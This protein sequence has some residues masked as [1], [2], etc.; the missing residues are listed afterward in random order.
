M[1]LI[2][3]I[4]NLKYLF[5]EIIQLNK[6]I[7]ELTRLFTTQSV[8]KLS[9]TFIRTVHNIPFWKRM[10]IF[11]LVIIMFQSSSLLT[12][13]F[14][15]FFL[16]SYTTRKYLPIVENVEDIIENKKL[17]VIANQNHLKQVIES[18]NTWLVK[19]EHLWKRIQKSNIFKTESENEFQNIYLSNQSL[20]SMIEGETVLIGHT[21]VK[22]LFL[23]FNDQWKSRYSVSSDK[24]I[25]S[26]SILYVKKTHFLSRQIHHM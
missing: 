24:Y 26:F 15:C 8:Q 10:A 12:K 25:S 17:N 9:A 18:N 7:E 14:N 5:R 16:K 20:I 11:L 4:I 1:T 3:T 6:L 23:E 19:F 2:F 21:I 22:K 13:A